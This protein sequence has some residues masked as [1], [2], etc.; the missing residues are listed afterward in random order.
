MAETQLSACMVQSQILNFSSPWSDP[1]LL[2]TM[3]R[4]QLLNTM[5][6]PQLLITMV[7]PQLKSFTKSSVRDVIHTPPPFPVW[8]LL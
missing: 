7:G 2:N 3:V 5:V 4:P 1:Q 6:R 8:S